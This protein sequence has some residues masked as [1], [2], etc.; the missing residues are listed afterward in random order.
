MFLTR[1]PTQLW[2][3]PRSKNKLT[4]LH[5]KIC[6]CAPPGVGFRASIYSPAS[7]LLAQ[8]RNNACER[9]LPRIL[10]QIALVYTQS[11]SKFLRDVL[12]LK[13]AGDSNHA[14]RGS[15]SPSWGFRPSV[16]CNYTGPCWDTLWGAISLTPTAPTA[17][18]R[19][20]FA[21]DF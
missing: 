3:A 18:S 21:L 11:R 6:P 17:T 5:S 2:K 19:G 9:Y 16:I 4:E 13:A 12:N 7:S 8:T 20:L 10:P 1:A 15:M 14:P